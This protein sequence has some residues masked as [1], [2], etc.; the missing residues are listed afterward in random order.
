[1]VQVKRNNKWGLGSTEFNPAIIATIVCSWTITT[2]S[3]V[4]YRNITGFK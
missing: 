3:N 2:L 1:V 4:K